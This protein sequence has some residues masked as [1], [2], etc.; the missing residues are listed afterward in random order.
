MEQASAGKVLFFIPDISGFTK[1][2]SE[3]EIDHSQHIIQEL[4]ETLVDASAMGL[5]VGEYEGDAVLFYRLGPPPALADFVDQARRMFIGFH[6]RLRANEQLR[7]CQCGACSGAP[8]L[9]LKIVAH[10][11]PASPMQV[12]G[13]MKFIGTGVIVAHRLLKNSTPS[14]E[15]L[16]LSR[17]LLDA[18]APGAGDMP[19]FTDGSDVFDEIGPVAYRH[20]SLQPYHAEVRVELPEPFVLKNPRQLMQL[21][22][23]I[24]APAE[25]VYQLM[26]DLPG[27]MKWIEGAKEVQLRQEGGNRI[28]AVHRCVRS[29]GDPDLVTSDVKITDSTL[30]FWETDV[31]KMGACR[32]LLR[33][34]AS[35]ETEVEL[36]FFVTGNPLVWWVARAFMADKLRV[37]F[38]KSLDKLA[39]LCE[40][41]AQ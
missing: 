37:G 33:R 28:G 34:A 25:Q 23:H 3:T 40:G 17:E 13:Q 18:L 41:T 21:S 9:T 27:R 12:K 29:G 35:D 24:A 4:L 22:R 38:T 2:V 16:L 10:F 6:T 30:E 19:A 26:I 8:G 7:I 31:K 11:G 36:E 32:F 15:Y 5:T 14:R 20:M 39:A 1:F